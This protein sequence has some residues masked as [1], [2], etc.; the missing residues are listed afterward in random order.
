MQMP[1]EIYVQ[2]IS[3]GKWVNIADGGMVEPG[4]TIR[5]LVSGLTG[6]ESCDP[7]VDVYN[8]ATDEKI[9]GQTL[10]RGLFG[11]EASVS[12]QAPFGEGTYLVT[13]S[14]AY[15]PICRPRHTESTTFTV[16]A[17]APPPPTPPPEEGNW[18]DNIKWI[19]ILGIVA[20]VIMYIPKPRT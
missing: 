6:L 15:F 5:L 18:W 4:E 12:I 13:A 17:S 8:A 3:A 9:F 19:L 16:S 1:H 14:S 10:S 7:G 20:M 11:S 2:R